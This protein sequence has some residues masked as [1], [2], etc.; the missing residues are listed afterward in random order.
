M[1]ENDKLIC[2]KRALTRIEDAQF[3][4][5]LAG[6]DSLAGLLDPVYIAVQHVLQE[7]RGWNGMNAD[8]VGSIDAFKTKKEEVK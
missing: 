4:L 3:E 2:F 7:T 8:Y 1:D 6:E 5:T